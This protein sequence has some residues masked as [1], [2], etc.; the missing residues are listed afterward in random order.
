MSYKIDGII[1]TEGNLLQIAE[2]EPGFITGLQIITPELGL[3]NSKVQFDP[4]STPMIVVFDLGWITTP[5]AC[6]SAPNATLRLTCKRIPEVADLPMYSSNILLLSYHC[7]CSP[8]AHTRSLQWYTTFDNGFVRAVDI[9]WDCYH[10]NVHNHPLA[11]LFKVEPVA[12]PVAPKPVIQ[13]PLH[14]AD[15]RGQFQLF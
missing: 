2:I 1:Y 11:D 9:G 7:K 6:G 13:E 3:L 15:R 12:K 10:S 8:L 5:L 14:Q 4:I